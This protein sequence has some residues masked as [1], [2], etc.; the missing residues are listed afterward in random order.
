MSQVEAEPDPDRDETGTATFEEE[1]H[2]LRLR[3]AELEAK[4]PDT[5]PESDDDES[6]TELA[7]AEPM[8]TRGVD[9]SDERVPYTAASSDL[10]VLA[11][12]WWNNWDLGGFVAVAYL[13]S[14]NDGTRPHGGF[15]IKESSLFV[16]AMAWEDVSFFLEIQSNRLGKDSEKFV[17]T[18][19]VNAHFRNLLRGGNDDTLLGLKVG[20][21]DIPFGEEYLWQ[22]AGDNPLISTSA[23]YPYGFDEGVLVYGTLR[24]V[25]WIAAITDG[26]DAQSV[27]D[28]PDKAINLKFYGNP[29]EALYLSGSFM[30]NGRASKSAFEFGGSH[31]QPVGV[32]RLS[33]VGESASQMVN[34]R[35]YEL[36]ATYTFGEPFAFAAS[37][38]QAFLDDQDDAFDRDLTW[39]SI[40]PRFTIGSG[41]YALL[42]YSEIGTYDS[43][44]GYQFDGKTTAGGNAFFGYDT[45]RFRRLSVGVGWR[46]NPRIVVKGEVGHD[47][48]D[49]IDAAPTSGV[50]EDRLLTGV[51][52]VLVF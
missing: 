51:E 15:L 21:V 12:P 24:G 4:P 22:D 26:T 34:A 7:S 39:F 49:V 32:S 30:R 44:R 23:A 8:R 47:W 33:S 3:I 2:E 13:D 17:R 37:F 36:D 38:G 31:F 50:G 14:G 42:R 43:T 9:L 45:R 20:R 28:D 46:P 16:E 40:E 29:S 6:E 25:G 11:R 1:V 10:H 52:L 19:E 5:V 18:G 41:K 27:E 48:F 35:L